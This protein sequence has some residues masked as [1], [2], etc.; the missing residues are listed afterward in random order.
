MTE[1]T[2]PELEGKD[3]AAEL[4]RPRRVAAADGK[5][6]QRYVDQCLKQDVCINWTLV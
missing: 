5:W 6:R 4:Q 3:N 1:E 2:A